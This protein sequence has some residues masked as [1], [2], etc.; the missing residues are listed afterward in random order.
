VFV[1]G[2]LENF[3]QV[4]K[5]NNFGATWTS[6]DQFQLEPGHWAAA[7][8]LT[9]DSL[10][11]LFAV[12]RAERSLSRRI[13]HFEWVVRQGNQYGFNPTP[14]DVFSEGAYG[15]GQAETVTVDATG[16]VQ[17]T[18]FFGAETGSEG[19]REGKQVNGLWSWSTT[20]EIG[21]HGHGRI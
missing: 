17:V 16:A 2:L 10:G 8:G 20:D 5:S 7:Y 9:S 21:L 14:I 15:G 12:G 6:I 3:W 19:V 18:G 4:Q 13:T 11:N 1:C